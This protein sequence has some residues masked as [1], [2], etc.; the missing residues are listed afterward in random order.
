M[1]EKRSPQDLLSGILS[2]NLRIKEA[3]KALAVDRHFHT[4]PSNPMGIGLAGVICC[5]AEAELRR[6]F[7]DKT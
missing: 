2:S 1:S 4:S 3:V 6:M 5:C 7:A